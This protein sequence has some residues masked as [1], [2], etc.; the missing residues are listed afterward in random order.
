[1]ILDHAEHLSSKKIVLASASPRRREILT[2]M[3]LP[4]DVV[5]STFEETLDKRTFA[6]PAA[7]AVANATGKAREV[8]ARAPAADLVIGSDTIVVLDGR[9]LEKPKSEAES[10]AM[11]KSLSGRKHTVVSAIA[12]FLKG[13]ADG[14][15]PAV[16]L[17]VE[18][19]V[20]FSELSD[21]LIYGECA[22]C[23]MKVLWFV[24]AVLQIRLP[25][26]PTDNVSFLLFV[27]VGV[28]QL[29]FAQGTLQTKRAAMASKA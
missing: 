21:D 29:T 20:T 12:L 11:L 28:L 16:A 7:Y 25:I 26:M 9:I 3:R 15:E 4:F 24:C 13:A 10:Y 27:C 14:A 2:L 8:A 23:C 18:T 17:P 5:V 1:M 6:T 19:E 22:I